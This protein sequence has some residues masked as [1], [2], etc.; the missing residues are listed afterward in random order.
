MGGGLRSWERCAR[1]ALAG[2]GGPSIFIRNW[3]NRYF[4]GTLTFDDP[5]VAD[6][7]MNKVPL[8]QRIFLIASGTKRTSQKRVTDARSQ[9]V[10]AKRGSA[11][12]DT[13]LPA[14]RASSHLPH[15]AVL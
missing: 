4:D 6:E 10:T 3:R 12:M 13:G 15:S 2:G 1:A 7:V 9:C 5:V 14:W 8:L 11:G